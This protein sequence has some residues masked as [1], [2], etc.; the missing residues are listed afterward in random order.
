MRYE[1]FERMYDSIYSKTTFDK[2]DKLRIERF[3]RISSQIGNAVKVLDF[4]GGDGD[5][6]VYLSKTC[7]YSIADLSSEHEIDS[8]DRI[9]LRDGSRLD[10]ADGIF[11]VVVMSE[12][13]E[14]VPNCYD[15]LSEIGRVLKPKG[16]LIITVPNPF[17]L[18]NIIKAIFGFHLDPSKEHLYWFDWSYLSNLLLSCGFTVSHKT[19]FCFIP[20]R[21]YRPFYLLDELVVSLFRNNGSQLLCVFER[22]DT[23][24]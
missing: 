20:S 18:L 8:F 14:H 24:G 23:E 17:S 2:N 4:G 21:F 9:V 7:K 12:V 10:I 3:K 16:R 11:D 22:H 19:T 6:S 1:Y 13:L 5:L 15:T